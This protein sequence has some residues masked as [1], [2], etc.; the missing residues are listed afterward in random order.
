MK[1]C[2]CANEAKSIHGRVL[3]CFNVGHLKGRIFAWSAGPT[4]DFSFFAVRS[5][6]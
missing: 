1:L 5:N 6:C 3:E 4:L 2:A